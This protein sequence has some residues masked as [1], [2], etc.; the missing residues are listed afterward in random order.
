MASVMKLLILESPS[1]RKTI[2]GF[3]GQ[4]WRVEASFGHVTELSDEGPDNLGFQLQADGIEPHYIP[5][6]KRGKQVLSKLQKLSKQAE[7]VYFATDPDREG[8]AIS[9]HL[10]EQLKLPD[11]K[12]KRV[13]Y[14][15][16][17]EKAVTAAI[18]QADDTIDQDLANAARARQALDKLVGYK[19]SPLLW[20]SS[21]LGNSVG[22]VQSAALAILCRREAE[23]REFTPRPYWS[24]WVQYQAGFKAHF[25]GTDPGAEEAAGDGADDDAASPDELPQVEGRRIWNSADAKQLVEIAHN[26]PHTV[27]SAEGHT[28]YRKAPAPFTTSTLQQAAGSNLGFS[29]GQTMKVAQQ[30]FEGLDLPQ[31]RKSLITYHRS[32]A[33]VLSEDFKATAKAW[34]EVNDP[35]NVP[36]TLP[37]YRAKK[38]AQAAHEAIRPTYLDIHPDSIKGAASDQQYQLYSLI[39]R[40]AMA[41]CCRPARLAKSRIV[42]ESGGIYWEARGQIVE[43]DGFARYWPNLGRDQELPA[44][45]E[46][47]SL[48]VAECQAE[49]RKTSAPPRYSEA[50]LVQTLEK[51]GVG[52]PS[53]FAATIQVLKRR[54]YVRI[55][56]RKLAPTKAGMETCRFLNRTV[57]DLL[58]S[59]FTAA[60]EAA[61]DAIAC[62]EKVWERYILNWYKS[63][64]SPALSKAETIVEA[65]YI[66]MNQS[67][68]TEFKCPVCTGPLETYSYQK[69]GALKTMLRCH[70]ANTEALQDNAQA[71]CSEVAFFE[72]R[73]AW[74]SPQ[75]GE[76]G[77][78]DLPDDEIVEAPCPVCQGK[79]EKHFYPK[80][81]EVKSM[82]RCHD[83]GKQSCQDVAFFETDEG[84]WSPEYGD[85][86]DLR[87]PSAA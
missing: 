66:D 73:G 44:V 54:Q 8:E 24:L 67:E 43:F 1:K 10:A 15:E 13:R 82:L 60:M 62:G 34:L 14:S 57:P 74:W 87:D 64:L 28:T 55:S 30:L 4:G 52:R 61:L 49:Q 35:D 80:D 46:G 53:T 31:G 18:A 9:W 83:K 38:G 19:L 40:R 29:T 81:G 11:S 79:L 12:I 5:R 76:I 58:D 7:Q 6:G 70:Q 2:Q 36:E 41:A 75:Y 48:E 42:T 26:S 22:R 77:E 63:Y 59:D 21:Q 56:K 78:S 25:L 71:G 72:S 50:R 3:L 32:D 65:E 33:P 51:V 17:T 39:W 47:Q 20:N 37:A 27:L 23:I 86:S 69:D 45:E 84:Y 85:L 68:V 16:I